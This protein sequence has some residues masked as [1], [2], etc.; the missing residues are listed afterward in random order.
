MRQC[1]VARN[2]WVIG[3]GSLLRLET[4]EVFVLFSYLLYPA[5]AVFPGI[6]L[7]V[8]ASHLGFGGKTKVSESIQLGSKYSDS[9][10]ALRML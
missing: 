6:K 8:F 3:E 5:G 7:F 1:G 2:F 4:R 10:G 9:Q